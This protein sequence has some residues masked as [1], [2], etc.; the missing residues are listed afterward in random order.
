MKSVFKHP[1]PETVAEINRQFGELRV[2]SA[3]LAQSDD[4]SKLFYDLMSNVKI[5]D[6]LKLV[7]LQGLETT[8]TVIRLEYDT[9]RVQGVEVPFDLTQDTLFYMTKSLDLL[10]GGQ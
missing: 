1:H 8:V 9:I 3:L 10:D 7:D 5:G 2:K 6:R 4:I